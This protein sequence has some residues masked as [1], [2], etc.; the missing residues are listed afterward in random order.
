MKL[1]AILRVKDEILCVRDCFSKL[2]ELV[3]EIVILD[4]GST[5]GTIEAFDKFDKIVK[6]IHTEGYHEG[7]DKCLLLEEAK[8]RNPDWIL[9]I[10]GDEIFEKNFTRSV[11]DEYMESKYNKIL[12]KL[13]HFWL[14]KEYFRINGPLFA[15]T[16]GPQRSM[17]RNAPDTHFSSRKMHN[18]DIRGIN[19]PFYVSPYRLKHYGCVNKEKMKEKYDRY[20]AVDDTGERNYE[21]MN[22]DARAIRLKFR[23]FDNYFVNLIYISIYKYITNIIHYSILVKRFLL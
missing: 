19:G 4:N 23:E 14:S 2:S 8:K 20:K 5:D 21:H 13:C 11:I 22:P 10:D 18:G 15:Y 9:W 12:F 16:V 6:I 3:D 17:W 1:V 7:R